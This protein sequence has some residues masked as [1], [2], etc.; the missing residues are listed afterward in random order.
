MP[1]QRRKRHHYTEEQRTSILEA[2][3]SGRLTALQVQKKFGVT[4]VTYYSWRKKTGLSSRRGG[5]AAFASRG[6]LGGHVRA[7]VQSKVRQLLPA[8]VRSEVSAYLNEVL[9][10]RRGRRLKT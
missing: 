1:K 6:D 3:K 7:E 5:L 4:P 10:T 8:I 2:A 9:G